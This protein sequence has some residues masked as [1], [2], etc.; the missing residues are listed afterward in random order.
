MAAEEPGTHTSLGKVPQQNR[1][2]GR[3]NH[4]S[5]EE[6]SSWTMGMAL[7]LLSPSKEGAEKMLQTLSYP[8]GRAA[9]LICHVMGESMP[10]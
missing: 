7:S 9:D 10:A 2:P 3:I 6:E 1:A 8:E 5:L 4:G